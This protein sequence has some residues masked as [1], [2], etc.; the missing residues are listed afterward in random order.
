MKRDELCILSLTLAF[1]GLLYEFVFAQTLTIV[2]GNT[3]LQ[4]ALTIGLFT[5]GLGLG[6]TVFEY[7]K[8]QISSPQK[9]FIKV[10]TLLMPL[11]VLGLFS[12]L[13]SGAWIGNSFFTYALSY[14]PILG[15]AFLTGFELPLIMEMAPDTTSSIEVLSYD[16]VGMF[17]A[18]FLFPFL[19]LPELGVFATLNICLSLNLATMLYVSH[20]NRTQLETILAGGFFTLIILGFSFNNQLIFYFGKILTE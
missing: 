19:L 13:F 14:F 17:L 9:A 6:A 16:F 2:F 10:Q 5:F 3:H 15:V 18:T 4:Y 7:L 11:A 8:K 20:K 1:V 12:I